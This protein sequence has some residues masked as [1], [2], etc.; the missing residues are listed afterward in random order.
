MNISSSIIHRLIWPDEAVPPQPT[1][2]VIF[3]S[4]AKPIS[5]IKHVYTDLVQYKFVSIQ[6]VS[7]IASCR[8]VDNLSYHTNY[9]TNDLSSMLGRAYS[10]VALTSYKISN[11]N[12]RCSLNSYYIRTCHAVA[13]F[14]GDNESVNV[15]MWNQIS[16]TDYHFLYR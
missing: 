13:I 2:P 14:V 6:Y 1:S 5:Y 9:V 7:S 3:P 10:L 4:P 11:Y 12:H 15:I 8:T 16:Q